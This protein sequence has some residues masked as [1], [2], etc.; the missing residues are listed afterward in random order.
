MWCGLKGQAETGRREESFMILSFFMVDE[1]Q[2]SAI[3]EGEGREGEKEE[4]EEEKGNGKGL[5]WRL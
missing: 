3:D 5:K 2:R 1:G 4:E